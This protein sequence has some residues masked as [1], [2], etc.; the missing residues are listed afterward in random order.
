MKLALART[1]EDPEV[2]GVGGEDPITV[3]EAVIRAY[4]KPPNSNI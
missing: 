3:A 2:K 4:T 1:V